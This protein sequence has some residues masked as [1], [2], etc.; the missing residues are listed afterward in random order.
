MSYD[1]ATF[2]VNEV[3][4]YL[5]KSRSDDPVLTVEEVLFKHETQLQ[6]YALSSFGENI[7]ETNIFREV[8]SG[9]TISDRPVMQQIMKLLETESI[10]AVLVIEPQRL[11]RGDLEDCGRI[12]NVFRYT[13]TLVLTPPKTYDLTD[14]YDRKFFEMELMRGNDYLE[15]T[16][17]ILNRG[18]IASVKQGNFIGSVPPYGYR[19]IKI[20]TGKNACYTLEIIPEEA[21]AL[22][23]MYHL[24]LDEGYG[25]SRIAQHLDSIGI[26]PRK[27]DNWSPAA[28]KDMLSNPVYIGKIRWNHAKTQKVMVNGQVTRTRPR[29]KDMS[30]W[31]YVD[32]KHPAIID[33]ATYQAVAERRGKSPKIKLSTELSNPFAG[34]LFCGSCGKAMSYKKFINKGKYLSE[35]MICNNQ[36][37]CKTKSV[38]YTAFLDRVVKSLSDTIADFEIKL[39]ND[40]GDAARMHRQTI[41]LLENDLLKLQ[42]KD[43]RQK[44][45]YED[46]V[47]TKA[48]YALRNAKLQEQI[49][50]TMEALA[51]AR[52]TIP[53][54][55]DYQ[56]KILRFTNCLNALQ[57][58]TVS[59]TEKNILLKSCIRKIVYHND[60]ESRTGIGRY[61][62]NIFSLDIFLR[63]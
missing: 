55:I 44:D 52:A 7:P 5:R 10:K 58:D 37:N 20:G 8:V 1:I 60:M 11:S 19:K 30:K 45:A 59:A 25:F 9:E 31:I 42:L 28:I 29:E 26:K 34:L 40:H 27:S 62:E 22:K 46:G 14:E 18:R 39:Q 2:S 23:I 16:K 56:E 38:Q 17:K 12:I 41:Q 32:G 33:E 15:Y 36:I 43:T 3:I 61:V 13:G 47:Y 21:E 54:E 51:N 4:I 50:Q 48:E 57:D 49:S 53:E 63:L 6:E 35:S 24:Y